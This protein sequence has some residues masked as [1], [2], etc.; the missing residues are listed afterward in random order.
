MKVGDNSVG[1]DTLKED[2]DVTTKIN[3]TATGNIVTIIITNI[4]NGVKCYYINVK[5][6]TA[7]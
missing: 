3:P 6:K 5:Y 7:N 1:N 2:K 4:A